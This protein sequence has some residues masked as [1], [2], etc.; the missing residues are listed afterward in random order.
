MSETD[1]V[2]LSTQTGNSSKASFRKGIQVL[3]YS[4]FSLCITIKFASLQEKAKSSARIKRED[5]I[6]PDKKSSSQIVWLNA[7]EDPVANL[8][9]FS[10]GLHLANVDNDGDFQLI[11]ADVGLCLF[12]L[13]FY[14]RYFRCS[15]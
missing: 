12:L 10:S 15:K 9:C 5:K 7:Y 6:M 8:R 13:V 14:Y 4:L 1:G 3:F 2:A 11:V